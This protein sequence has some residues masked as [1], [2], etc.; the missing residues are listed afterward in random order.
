VDIEEGEDAVWEDNFV[1]LV[2]G[3]AV[4]I[5]VEGLK[6]RKAKARWLGDWEGEVGF[7]L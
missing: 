4:R 1:D 6:G 3:E 7:E 2:P 5:G